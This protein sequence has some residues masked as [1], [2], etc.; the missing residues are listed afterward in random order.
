MSCEACHEGFIPY[1]PLDCPKA[2]DDV[3]ADDLNFALCQCSKGRLLR[4]NQNNGRKVTPLWRV[5]CAAQQIDPSR[6]ALV[7]DVFS[8]EQ[9]VEMGLQKATQ[10]PPVD[11]EAAMLAAGK[12]RK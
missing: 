4:S 5:W 12:R 3:T 11:R 9:L 8:W 1:A 6:V 2:D 7:E 10:L